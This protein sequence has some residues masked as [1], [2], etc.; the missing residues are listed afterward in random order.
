MATSYNDFSTLHYQGREYYIVYID[1]QNLYYGGDI[2]DDY[3][4]IISGEL[5][6]DYTLPEGDQLDE[7]GNDK[8]PQQSLRDGTTPEKALASLPD[9]LRCPIMPRTRHLTKDLLNNM[10]NSSTP[11]AIPTSAYFDGN[12]YGVC[13]LIKRTNPYT[14]EYSGIQRKTSPAINYDVPLYPHNDTYSANK[15]RNVPYSLR[16]IMFLGCPK[17]TDD[18]WYLLPD[19]LKTDPKWGASPAER[20]HI[21]VDITPDQYPNIVEDSSD[22]SST[23]KVSNDGYNEFGIVHIQ[24][25][26]FQS[27]VINRCYIYRKCKQYEYGTY[28]M[29]GI[30]DIFNGSKR[31]STNCVIQNSKFGFCELTSREDNGTIK[32]SEEHW[33]FENEKW[34]K[35]KYDIFRARRYFKIEA[36]RNCRFDNNIINYLPTNAYGCQYNGPYGTMAGHNNY[37]YSNPSIFENRSSKWMSFYGDQYNGTRHNGISSKALSD[38]VTLGPYGTAIQA[39]HNK[40]CIMTAPSKVGW[41]TNGDWA[42]PSTKAQGSCLVICSDNKSGQDNFNYSAFYE[43]TNAEI[44]DL[45]VKYIFNK[46]T[47]N[48]N[49]VPQTLNISGFNKT[50]IKNITADFQKDSAGNIIDAEMDIPVSPESL[51]LMY[52]SIFNISVY[53]FDIKNIDIKL[54]RCWRTRKWEQATPYVLNIRKKEEINRRK[55]L[56][57]VETIS[58]ISVYMANGTGEAATANEG[59]GPKDN[60]TKYDRQRMA[61]YLDFRN[62]GKQ[63]V[64]ENGISV[65]NYWG[66]GLYARGMQFPENNC[67]IYGTFESNNSVGTIEFV[68]SARRGNV[69]NT[70]SGSVIRVK[71]VMVDVSDKTDVTPIIKNWPTD[72]RFFGEADDPNYR[73]ISNDA[74]LDRHGREERITN[75]GDNAMLEN[76]AYLLIDRCNKVILSDIEFQSTAYGDNFYG[77]T[78]LNENDRTFDLTTEEDAVGNGRY[79]Q[80]TKNYYIQPFSIRRKAGSQASLLISNRSGNEDTTECVI[81]RIP[82]KGIQVRCVDKD[83]QQLKPGKYKLELFTA[84]KNWRLSSEFLSGVDIEGMKH[85]DPRFVDQYILDDYKN[86]LAWEAVLTTTLDENNKYEKIFSSVS[87]GYYEMKTFDDHI[88]DPNNTNDPEYDWEWEGDRFI[89]TYDYRFKSTIIVNIEDPT[90]PINVRLHF[91][92][93]NAQGGTFYVDPK[94]QLKPLK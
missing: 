82:F 11:F 2:K 83:G 32:W 9:D 30:F 76:G 46:A 41:D 17:E 1:P 40:L 67:R 65:S 87:D 62:Y 10:N 57:R 21:Y 69:L 72:N 85:S 49:Y 14:G 51:V 25:P 86:I 55:D 34:T 12:K 28:G 89:N 13:Y 70:G 31:S 43:R 39:L 61:L 4:N 50:I 71:K 20:A 92:T 81:G 6:Q 77:I 45:K 7:S 66:A 88:A 35:A 93:Y 64:R 22:N 42:Y 59:Y 36:Y 48:P 52:D 23:I 94:M 63:I 15:N 26:K 54:S 29:R 5:K 78:C 68:K 27:I 16:N 75:L 33:N 53:Q 47:T 18:L 74:W 24:D 91:N 90:K 60:T 80:R 84:L 37:G 38:G 44:Y 58:N 73:A 19:E 8:R 79:V 56:G 3:G